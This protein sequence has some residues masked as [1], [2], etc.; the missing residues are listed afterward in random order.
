MD[1]YDIIGGAEA[2]L[3]EVAELISS[4]YSSDIGIDIPIGGVNTCR[5]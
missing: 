1:L 4:F 2:H 3:E 5:P